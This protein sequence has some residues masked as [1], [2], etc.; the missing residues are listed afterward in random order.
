MSQ[1]NSFHL[2]PHLPLEIRLLIWELSLVPRIIPLY[3]DKFG[4]SATTS[5]LV[6][7]FWNPHLSFTI[8]ENQSFLDKNIHFTTSISLTR[9]PALS[10]CQESR[11][12]AVNRGYR[13]WKLKS[14]NDD[15]VRD[16]M[17]NPNIDVVSFEGSYKEWIPC[18]Y[19]NIFSTQF[20]AET[21]VVQNL[22]LPRSSFA[23]LENGKKHTDRFREFE[24]LREI[25]VLGNSGFENILRWRPRDVAPHVWIRRENERLEGVVVE[26]LRGGVKEVVWE[27]G[28]FGVPEVRTVKDWNILG[29]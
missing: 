12:A 6:R 10:A 24:G 28:P 29:G 7:H 2:F 13:P 22:A 21:K 19:T 27:W 15:G 9:V 18:L 16:V 1:P 17:W 4:A 26:S 5:T 11:Q 23:D 3:C 25:I 8:S 14:R 20:P